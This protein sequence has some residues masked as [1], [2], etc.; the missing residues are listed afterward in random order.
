M[1]AILGKPDSYLITQVLCYIQQE[2]KYMNFKTGKII[3]VPTSALDL[4]QGEPGSFHE[5][6]AFHQSKGCT[7]S[8]D[9]QSASNAMTTFS[10]LGVDE[11]VRA[12][13]GCLCSP[14]TS[15]KLCTCIHKNTC[16]R[17]STLLGKKN[18]MTFPTAVPTSMKF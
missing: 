18:S 9:R 7:S 8:V 14:L 1:L 12:G 10:M 13:G 17:T 2:F 11:L 3:S 5:H 4:V 6:Q 16:T 15:L